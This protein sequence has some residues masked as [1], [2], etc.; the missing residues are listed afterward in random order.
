[1]V[2]GHLTKADIVIIGVIL[3]SAGVSLLHTIMNKSDNN[4]VT[5]S[6][7]NQVFG[8]EEL[9]YSNVIELDTLVVVEIL[10]NRARISFSTCRNQHCVNQGWSNSLPV[11]C[12]PNKVILEFN[13]N[14]THRRDDIFITY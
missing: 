9:R 5:I 1:M 12:V 7:N 2:F 10:D 8:I 6:F 11:I 3:L 14:R 13:G 4:Q